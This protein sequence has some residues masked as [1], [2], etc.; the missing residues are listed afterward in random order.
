MSA[1]PSTSASAASATASASASVSVPAFAPG[2]RVLCY[3]GPLVYEAKVLRTET[4]DARNTR[5]GALGPHFLVHYKGWKQTW[6]EWV[7][8]TRLLK[9]NETNLA[10]QKALQQQAS[11]ASAS[12][13]SSAG[14]GAA[15]AG[16]GAKDGRRKDG[17]GTK[18]GREED[19]GARRPEMKLSVPEALKVLLVDDW[20]AVTKNN[21][22][23]RPP[24][25]PS[26][27]RAHCAADAACLRCHR[28]WACTVRRG[29]LVPLPRSPNVLELL[30]EFRAHVL[31]QKPPQCVAFP[32]R[33]RTPCAH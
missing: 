28:H 25:S 32:P 5:T 16:V 19:E 9:W 24:P 13:A 7:H 10:L 2:E 1:A 17:R 27:H 29:Q 12:A 21:Q 15:R 22:V 33:S 6:D 11:A 20:E 18:R 31:A 14:K 4:W 8:V 26:A 3:H 30:E 23:R